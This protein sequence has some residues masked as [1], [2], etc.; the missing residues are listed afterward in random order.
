MQYSNQSLE[1]SA[2]DVTYHYLQVALA[3]RRNAD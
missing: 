1:Y 2:L 3:I